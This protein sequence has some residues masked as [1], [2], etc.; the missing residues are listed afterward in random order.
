MQLSVVN[1]CDIVIAVWLL[2]AVLDGVIQGLILKLGQIAAVVAAYVLANILAVW[3]SGYA[4]ITFLLSYLVLSV[5]FRLL[6]TI[7]NLV[8]RVPVIGL[9]NHLAGAVCGFLAAFILIYLLAHLVFGAV[10]QTALDQI[11][12]TREAVEHSVLLG[13]FVPERFGG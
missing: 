6:V 12:L 2:L 1:V 3:F 8:D 10:P 7:L 5:V 11:G 9:L 4:G 13:A